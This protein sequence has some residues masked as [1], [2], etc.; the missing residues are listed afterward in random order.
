MRREYL[1]RSEQRKLARKTA[2]CRDRERDTSELECVDGLCYHVGGGR[3]TLLDT[4]NP[5]DVTFKGREKCRLKFSLMTD[6]TLLLKLVILTCT[7]KDIGTQWLFGPILHFLP[8]PG[9]LRGLEK[10]KQ[11]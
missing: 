3:K 1:Y 8:S 5:T 4:K 10:A 11:S 2:E 9:R 6:L 7:K